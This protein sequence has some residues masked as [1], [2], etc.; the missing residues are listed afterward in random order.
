MDTM[1]YLISRWRWILLA[2][3][4]LVLGS[5]LDNESGQGART[6]DIAITE[7]NDSLMTFDSL[8]IKVF[9]KDSSVVQEI[10][11]GKL[12]DKN[13][14]LGIPLKLGIGDS[15]TVV[16]KGYRNGK[17]AMEKQVAV[18]G[19]NGFVVNEKP[20][21]VDSTPIK[22]DTIKPLT[23]ILE[24]PIDTNI[25]E[26]DSLVMAIKVLNTTD[27]SIEIK[28]K[29]LP[30]GASFRMNGR[31]QG[32][33]SWR[34]DFD[35]GQE[36]H[37]A[38]TFYSDLRGLSLEKTLRI[39]VNNVNRSPVLASIKNQVAKENARLILA[40]KASDPDGNSGLIVS[41]D[42]LPRGASFSQDTF[43]WTPAYDQ[44]GNYILAFKVTDGEL[45]D[46]QAV[47]ITVGDFNRPPDL[48]VADT[49]IF[50]ND[51]LELL[52]NSSDPDGSVPRLRAIGTPEGGTF[53]S[54]DSTK[55]KW[56]FSWRPTYGQGRATP[57]E[58]TF[59]SSD[60]SLETS[61]TVKIMVKNVN[62]LPS[63]NAGKDTSLTINDLI[64]L[65]GSGTD[66]DG[67]IIKWE[68][69]IGGTGA[70]T[71]T[72]KSDTS[73]KAPSIAIAAFKCIL[74]A[75][76]N[77]GVTAIDSVS[78]MVTD[79]P[80]VAK[81]GPDTLVDPGGEVRLR[82]TASD[83]GRLEEVGWVCDGS[84]KVS[85]SMSGLETLFK[86]R[87]LDDT[88]YRCI[89]KVTDDDGMSDADTIQIR[90]KLNW[91]KVSDSA[92]FPG[93]YGA[94]TV[95]FRDR[96]W[97]I[98]GRG[99]EGQHLMDVWSSADGK[100]WRMESDR[101]ECLP[102]YG[103]TVLSHGGKLWVIG[104]SAPIG[105]SIYRSQSDIWSSFDG[106]S[107]TR[108]RDS[109]GFTPRVNHAAVVF[110]NKMWIMG[111]EDTR[112]IAKSLGDVWYS[113][114]GSNWLL[115]NATAFSPRVFNKAVVFNSRIW[116]VGGFEKSDILTSP[117]G[118]AW[119]SHEIKKPFYPPTHFFHV[120]VH[121]EKV[122]AWEDNQVWLTTDLSTWGEST[123][124]APFV[125]RLAPLVF[126]GRLW[127]FGERNNGSKVVHSVWAN[128]PN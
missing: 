64:L 11:N 19:N 123:V 62:L 32:V 59:V 16:I 30:R 71:R 106:I 2:I 9:S 35:Q 103:H 1:K 121:A 90:A 45:R 69:D 47:T 3:I 28:G 109:A 40:V 72:S 29:D 36:A 93:R 119:T 39:H 127:S 104:G 128:Q 120:V 126:N 67:S 55:G 12:T 58:I 17:L 37:Y 87:E 118:L 46:S 48:E 112:G 98:G 49:T 13:Q 99:T 116:V 65:K 124:S 24:I 63:A 54:I 57:Y 122:W 7:K 70:F 73:I 56:K 97:I 31:Y 22:P 42:S 84:G 68:W 91:T 78:I 18:N 38:V 76:D 5:C 114:D 25:R 82:G 113:E 85:P 20:V 110:N 34:P 23:P 101:A 89:F 21:K 88:L 102:R 8:D 107:W 66:P 83:D 60:D 77:D 51:S 52:V 100:S 15:F 10:L 80:P 44:A 43:S 105:S 27:S 41:V 61:K 95:V 53:R 125:G 75:T 117:D 4:T 92:G 26:G 50:E 111:G 6:L 96:M 14:L 33:F 115:G 81:T 86:I 79:N 108:V 74:R 94:S